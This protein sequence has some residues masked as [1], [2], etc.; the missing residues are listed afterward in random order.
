MPFNT[1]TL[2][3]ETRDV[4]GELSRNDVTPDLEKWWLVAR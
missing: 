1:Q 3:C 2:V 4:Q